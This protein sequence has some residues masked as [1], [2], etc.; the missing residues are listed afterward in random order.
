M[1][2]FNIALITLLLISC[3]RYYSIKR[4]FVSQ[5]EG[6]AKP[7]T[8]LEPIYPR[9]AAIKSIQGKVRFIFDIDEDG[10]AFNIRVI[11]SIPDAIFD[12]SGLKVIKE[13]R[14][15]TGMLEG[16]PIPLKNRTLTIEF[17]I[18]DSLFSQ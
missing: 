1:K 16:K 4:D 6:Q 3:N 2:I 9:K 13:S 10:K 17:K 12:E 14:F 11:E 8:I 18:N 7:L 5:P 15:K